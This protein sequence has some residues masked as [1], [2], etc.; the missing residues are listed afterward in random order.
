MRWRRPSYAHVRRETQVPRGIGAG[1]TWVAKVVRL[2]QTLRREKTQTLCT[3]R[4]R[5]MQRE[6]HSNLG[7][8]CWTSGYRSPVVVVH[9]SSLVTNTYY[10]SEDVYNMLMI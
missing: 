3:N 4:L 8:L 6:L 2:T 10:K 5:S 1:S 7:L 9:S